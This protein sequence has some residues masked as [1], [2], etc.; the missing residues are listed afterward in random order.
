MVGSSFNLSRGRAWGSPPSETE[1]RRAQVRNGRPANRVF[2]YCPPRAMTS[3]WRT[4][5]TGPPLPYSRVKSYVQVQSVAGS[6]VAVERPSPKYTSVD[7]LYCCPGISPVVA[8]SE[9]RF[10]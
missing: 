5:R 7:T 1:P 8:V 9:S 6:G 3:S 2:D 10:V 4:Y